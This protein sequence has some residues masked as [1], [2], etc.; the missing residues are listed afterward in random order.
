MIGQ[1]VGRIDEEI[2]PTKITLGIFSQFAEIL[3]ELRLAGALGEFGAGLGESEFGQPLHQ[4]RPREGPSQEDHVRVAKLDFADQPLPEPQRLAVG[5]V[6]PENPDALVDPE[7]HQFA[8]RI[9]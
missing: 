1:D 8:Q 7:Q 3:L 5:I 9:P 4:F 2:R 6:G